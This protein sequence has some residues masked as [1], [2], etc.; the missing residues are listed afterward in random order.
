[1]VPAFTH[2]QILLY[3]TCTSAHPHIYGLNVA[4]LWQTTLDTCVKHTRNVEKINKTG[5]GYWHWIINIPTIKLYCSVKCIQ[6]RTRRL[7]TDGQQRRHSQRGTARH[8]VDVHPKRHPGDDHDQHGRQITLDQMETH[9]TAQIELGHQTTVIAWKNRYITISIHNKALNSS[10][11]ML[12]IYILYYTYW[13]QINHSLIA[14]S[15]PFFL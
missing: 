9:A 3:H 13:L 6:W 14:R 1:V 5:I 10:D 11:S 7:R 4:D 15:S 8:R 2:C 12:Y